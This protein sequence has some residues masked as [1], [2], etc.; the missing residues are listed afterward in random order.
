MIYFDQSATTKPSETAVQAMLDAL[1]NSYANPSSTHKAGVEIGRKVETARKDV[2]S[3]LFFGKQASGRLIFTSSGTEANN[4]AIIG[5][6]HSKSRPSNGTSRGTILIS[7]SEHA[8]VN[9]ACASLEAEGFTVKTIRT[10]GG[11]LSMEDA[12]NYADGSVIL[13]SCMLAN[14][15]T[16]A[17]YDVKTLFDIVRAKAPQA[18]CH[19]DA[20]QA[21]MKIKFTPKTIGADMVTISGHKIGAAK[22]IGALYISDDVIKA[23]KITPIIYGGGQESALRSGTLNSPGILSFGAAAKADVQDFDKRFQD[24]VAVRNRLMDALSK[25]QGIR[26]NIPEGQHVPGIISVTV[27]S[28]KSETML[29]YMSAHDVCVSAGSA[30]ASHGTHVSRPLAAFGLTDAEA[31]CTIRLSFNHSNTAEE[32]DQFAS[33]LAEGVLSLVHI[34]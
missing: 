27:F 29:N 22:G 4:L 33:F 23:K 20:V 1:Q 10:N 7:D 2:L 3:A 9:A 31:D 16:G 25:I 32:A 17:L 24:T 28:I 30:C 19:C 18:V 14:N 6:V 21:F 15:E 11:K 34:K 5:S 8:S 12:R 26:M 13:C